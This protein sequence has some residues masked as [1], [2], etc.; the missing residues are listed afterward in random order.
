MNE[1]KIPDEIYTSDKACGEFIFAING[2]LSTVSALEKELKRVKEIACNV[3]LDRLEA[4]GQKHFAFEGLGTFSKK[5]RTSITFPTE[6]NGGKE[7]AKQ[8]LIKCLEKG[9]ITPIQLLDV[10]KSYANSEPILAVEEAAAKYNQQQELKGSK[11]LIPDSPFNHFEKT[12]LS[13]PQTRK[14]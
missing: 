14:A 7:K 3:M 4:T 9:I 6:E 13:T 5:V 11:D 12:I 2:R 10:Q 1:I 8:W